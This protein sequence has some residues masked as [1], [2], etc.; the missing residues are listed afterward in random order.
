MALLMACQSVACRSDDRFLYW[1]AACLL[2]LGSAGTLGYALG[3]REA[4]AYETLTTEINRLDPGRTRHSGDRRTCFHIIYR[5]KLAAMAFGMPREVQFEKVGGVERYVNCDAESLTVTATREKLSSSRRRKY[6][7]ILTVHPM[8]CSKSFEEK[9]ATRLLM[10]TRCTAFA[11]VRDD[12]H[13]FFHHQPAIV[14]SVSTGEVRISLE[15]AVHGD[16]P[17]QQLSRVHGFFNM[18]A[19]RKFLPEIRVPLR[20]QPPGC[21]IA[22]SRPSHVLPAS[23]FPW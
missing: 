21:L 5:G 2:F 12:L 23:A 17:Q 15:G 14:R 4:R 16:M 9:S 7:F 11:R 8:S 19:F 20:W 18:K 10:Q 6:K 22:Y 1:S 3:S 13:R